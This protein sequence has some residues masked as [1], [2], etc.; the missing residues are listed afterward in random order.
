MREYF[1]ENEAFSYLGLQAAAHI[2]SCIQLTCILVSEHIQGQ[3]LTISKVCVFTFTIKGEI[4]G[5][6][7]NT[8]LL[9]QLE[10]KMYKKG[11]FFLY[12]LLILFCFV[13]VSSTYS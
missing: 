11:A 3:N 8:L 5:A 6:A 13:L 12:F 7:L 4:P 9:Q 2:G 10:A 1:R